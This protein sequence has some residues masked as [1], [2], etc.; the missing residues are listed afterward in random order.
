[1]CPIKKYTDIGALRVGS[2]GRHTHARTV[3]ETEHLGQW[4]YLLRWSQYAVCDLYSPFLLI[5]KDSERWRDGQ[6]GSVDL[7]RLTLAQH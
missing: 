5:V 7:W 2:T 3:G 4:L 1:M 6:I